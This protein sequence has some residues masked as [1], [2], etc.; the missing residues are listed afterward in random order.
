MCCRAEDRISAA[1]S[2]L[3]AAVLAMSPQLPAGVPSLDSRRPGDP[4]AAVTLVRRTSESAPV[5]S[6]GSAVWRARRRRACTRCVGPGGH[7]RKLHR[8]APHSDILVMTATRREHRHMSTTEVVGKGMSPGPIEGPAI[9]TTKEDAAAIQ[10]RPDVAHPRGIL[11]AAEQ[12]RQLRQCR[13]GT[14]P[15]GRFVRAFSGMRTALRVRPNWTGCVSSWRPRWSRARSAWCRSWKPPADTRRQ[16]SWLSWRRWSPGTGAFTLPTC[17]AKGT[18]S[19]L[20]REAIEIGEKAGVPVEIFH[21][22]V[23]APTI[24]EECRRWCVD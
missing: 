9:E 1:A 7:P 12:D 20:I 4:W 19:R 17:A 22:K 2:A 15:R 24:G 14:S 8:L 11:R 6:S 10:D 16:R 3:L 21:L 13:I 5:A 18:R 23:A